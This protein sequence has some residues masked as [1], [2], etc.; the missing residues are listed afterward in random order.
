[1][2]A[3]FW[4]GQPQVDFRGKTTSARFSHTRHGECFILRQLLSGGK[5]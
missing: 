2:T 4:C 3:S 5:P 1:M